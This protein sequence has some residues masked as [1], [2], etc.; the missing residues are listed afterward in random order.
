M[1][2]VIRF[3]LWNG[4]K[5]RADKNLSKLNQTNIMSKKNNFDSF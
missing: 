5:R 2:Q 1:Q 3:V 4:D